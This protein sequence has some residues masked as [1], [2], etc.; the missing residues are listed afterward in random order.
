MGGNDRP[1]ALDG[2]EFFVKD[3]CEM[4]LNEFGDLVCGHS[5]WPFRCGTKS[6]LDGRRGG[7]FI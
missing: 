5:A 1:F 6:V 3:E 7:C 2:L 4:H